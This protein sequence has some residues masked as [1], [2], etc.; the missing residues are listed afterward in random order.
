M[1]QPLK[2][3]AIDTSLSACSAAI[4]VDDRIQEHFIETPRQQAEMI[5]PMIEQL[6]NQA[7]LKLSDLQA[8]AFGAGPGSF[9]GMRVAAAT[10]Q[11]L[12]FANN[13]PVIRISTLQA[14]AQHAFRKF[15][16]QRALTCI[17]AQRQQIYWGI[18]LLG[19]NKLMQPLQTDNLSLPEAVTVPQEQHWTGIGNGW[20]L[21]EKI[22]RERC[23]EKL[24]NVMP[25]I[26]PHAQDVAL[27][28]ASAFKQGK[29]ET[30]EQA[31]P[32]YL[33]GAEYWKKSTL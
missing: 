24:E 7:T 17:D 1:T 26:Q 5:L 11:G 21:H 31:L 10:I 19:S 20:L 15:G 13:I 27:L 18:Y 3:L 8:I 33:R 12:A 14:L 30:A 6:L 16:T 2:I 22:L 25:E 29:I 32:I 23:G 9:T 28:A 4:L